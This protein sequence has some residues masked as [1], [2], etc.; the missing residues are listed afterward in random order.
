MRPQY[1]RTLLLTAVATLALWLA[2]GLAAA[3]ETGAVTGQV[4]EEGSGRPL[5]GA[6]VYVPNTQYG[7]ITTAAGR[8]LLPGLPA[9]THT[10][11]VQMIGY[12]SA[13]QRITITAGQTVTASFTLS[14]SAIALDE[15]VVT[16]SGVATEKK[17]LGNTVA[18]IDAA[19]LEEAPIISFSE[20]LQGREAGVS[21]M[22]SGGLTGEGTRIRIRGSNSLAMSNEPIVY[23]NGVRINNG[24]GLGIGTGGGGQPSRLD[25]IDP[26]SIER[27]EILK[28]AA[29]A[30]LYGSEASGGVIQIFTKS[31]ARAGVP[32]RW[33]F[34]VEQGFLEFPDVYKPVA[35]FTRS[36][37]PVSVPAG[38]DRGATELSTF[39]GRTITPYEVFEIDYFDRLLETGRTGTFTGSVSGGTGLL[40]YFVSGRYLT[41]DGPV[42]AEDFALARDT[43][44][45]AQGTLSL[46]VYPREDLE[47]R[48]TSMYTDGQFNTLNNNNNIYAPFTLAMFGKPEIA[49]CFGQSTPNGDG[50]CTGPD[51]GMGQGNEF[52]TAAFATVRE[53]LQRGF[54][55]QVQHYA[56]SLSTNYRPSEALNLT[57]TFGVDL[58]REHNFLFYPFGYNLDGFTSN[59][60]DGARTLVDRGS[61]QISADFRGAWDATFGDSWTSQLVLGTQ[62]FITRV[63]DQTGDVRNFPGPGFEVLTAGSVQNTTETFESVVNAGV[64]AQEQIGWNDWVF[65]TVGGR[66]DWNSAFGEAAGG[67][68]YPKVSLSVVPSERDSWSNDLFSTFR[69]RAAIGQSGLQPSAFAKLT[70]YQSIRSEFGA[71]V[72][73]AN[74]GNPDLKPEVATE[75]EAGAEVGLFRDRAAIDFTYWDRTVNDALVSR[76]FPVTGGFLARQLVNIGEMKASGIELGINGLLYQ[77]GDLSINLFG[78]AAYL[79]EEVTDLG[80]APALKVGGSYTRYRNWIKE[81]YAPGAFF[82]PELD[83]SAQY[84]IDTNA[85]CVADTEATLLA[86]FA[87]PREA[88]TT[89]IRPLVMDC[90]GDFLGRYVGKPNPDWSG[91]FGGGLT[92]RAFKVN[93]LFE[94]K[95]GN[96]QVHNLT[97][98]FRRAHP[99]LGGNLRGK[100]EVHAVLV[101]PASSPQQRLQ[102]ANEYVREWAA[103]APFDGL[104]E[105]EDA[106][107]IRWRELSLTAGVPSEWISRFGATGASV[108]FTGRNL[109]FL[110]NKYSGTDPEAN[111]N[112]RCNGTGGTASLDCNF[113]SGIDAFGFP[114]PRRF[115]VEARVSF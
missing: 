89:A 100:A 49:R 1:H 114:L 33:D 74:L 20:A 109:G 99:A 2:P 39:W 108:T 101:N 78:N 6:Q 31:G 67:A 8:F 15:V 55:Q 38:S 51:G 73:P 9:G 88:T 46:T 92:W 65:A 14:Q 32:T 75:W 60:V 104:H 58:T 26:N 18:T 47:L 81:G 69:V 63:D 48:L 3:Q 115:A 110:M 57:A 98:G 36:A 71:G 4:S 64:L 62:G 25:D 97:D 52:G 87:S 112:G 22:P 23:L 85:D 41:E 83:V 37:T 16:G 111:L 66:Y 42:G 95:V 19:R 12:G 27:I 91:G 40:S 72:R 79:K 10:L 17:K 29:A 90:K 21:A 44:K 13:D 54:E 56:G 93:T 43:N 84:P 106:D 96:F 77:G 102:A 30:T 68:F 76:Q 11:R 59:N 35:G 105:I 86:Y 53:T 28:G 82:G 113:G 61:R 7:T 5:A 94:Y 70:T 45:K 80:G 34:S 103:L 50:T 24:G 107:F